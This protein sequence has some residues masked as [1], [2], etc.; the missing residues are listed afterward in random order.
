MVQVTYIDVSG[1]FEGPELEIPPAH[2]WDDADAILAEY[3]IGPIDRCNHYNEV[4]PNGYPGNRAYLRSQMRRRLVKA[5][6]VV[7]YSNSTEE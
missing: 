3:G 7:S 5:G 4:S 6:H 2:E 1:L